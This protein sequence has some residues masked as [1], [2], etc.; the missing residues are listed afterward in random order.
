MDDS[1]PRRLRAVTVDPNTLIA[2][3]AENSYG[4]LMSNE[5]KHLRQHITREETFLDEFGYGGIVPAVVDAL[6]PDEWHPNYD[7]D[8][9]AREQQAYFRKSGDLQ[10]LVFDAASVYDSDGTFSSVQIILGSSSRVVTIEVLKTGE[11]FTA[12]KLVDQ[13]R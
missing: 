7:C 1:R 9:A 12:R 6:K 5:R 4:S 10:Q 2:S 3:R 13:P 8:D 11:S